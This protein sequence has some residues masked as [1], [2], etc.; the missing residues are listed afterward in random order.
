MAA[1]NLVTCLALATMAAGGFLPGRPEPVDLVRVVQAFPQ[2]V[3][4]FTSTNDTVMLCT[5]ATRS[6]VDLEQKKGSYVW[7]L[8]GHGGT[9]KRNLTVNWQE[10]DS[11]DRPTY[12]I[13]NDPTHHHVGHCLYTDYDACL[14]LKMFVLHYDQ[15]ML[16]VK[17]EVVDE[18][19]RHCRQNYERYC[20]VRQ[21]M[22][23]RELCEDNQ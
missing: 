14:V 11:P 15:C 19:P 16:W 23:N 6:Y 18:I 7:E 1:S 5:T 20:H 8:K 3:N 17:P 13:D 22:Y 9:A 4:V 2:F 10:G 12:Y 21:A